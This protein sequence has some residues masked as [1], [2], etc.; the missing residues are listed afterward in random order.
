MG[1]S[2]GILMFS[3]AMFFVMVEVRKNCIFNISTNQP[4]MCRSLSGYIRDSRK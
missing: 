3:V 4:M 2:L 1:T